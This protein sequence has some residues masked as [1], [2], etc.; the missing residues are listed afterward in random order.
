[1][2]QFKKISKYSKR[3]KTVDFFSFKFWIPN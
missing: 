1:M 3:L 2:V